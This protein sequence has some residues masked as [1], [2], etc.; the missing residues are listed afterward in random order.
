MPT[1]DVLALSGLLPLITSTDYVLVQDKV[2]KKFAKAY[3]QD[4]DLFFKEYVSTF[5]RA[6]NLD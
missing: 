6:P 5:S 3:A 4:Q 2:F 1:I